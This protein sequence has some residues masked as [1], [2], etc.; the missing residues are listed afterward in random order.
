[1]KIVLANGCFDGLHVG[2]MI[3][4][5]EA[6]KMGDKLVV[7][8]TNDASVREEKGFGHPFFSQSERKEMLEC[9]RYVDSVIIV[10]SIREAIETV[11]PNIFVKGP[12]YSLIKIG[13][14][15]MRLCAREGIDICC[16]DGPKFSSTALLSQIY[17]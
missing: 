8:L 2:H 16:T 13:D 15:V 1:M 4:L 12:D 7:A 6:K 5:I 3:H 10:S 9:Q 17:K 11:K 14:G